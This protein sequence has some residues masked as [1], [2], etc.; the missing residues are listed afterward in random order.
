[1][2]KQSTS[3]MP[4]RLNV[5]VSIFIRKGGQLLCENGIFQNCLYLVMLLNRSPRVK[6]TY[7]VTG[8]GDGGP[9]DAKRFLVDSPRRSSTWQRP[10]RSSM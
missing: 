10:W 4:E 9:E 5:G 6:A 1:M 3:R 2:N 7:L 8:G